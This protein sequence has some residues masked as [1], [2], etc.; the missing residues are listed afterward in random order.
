MKKFAIKNFALAITLLLLTSCSGGGTSAPS[1]DAF[2]SGNGSILQISPE[3]RGVAPTLSGK[4]L[5][6][7][8]T[9]SAGKVTIVNVWA[10]WCSPCRAEAPTLQALSTT[11]PN[12]QFVG[13]LTRD[14]QVTARAFVKRFKIAYPTLVDDAL[15]V[16]FP[17]VTPNA[18]PTTLVLDKQNRVAARISGE[19][20]YTDLKRIINQVS[21]EQ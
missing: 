20:L 17:G 12:V 1:E 14:N 10:S 21:A 18:I 13:I 3:K 6:G 9:Q 2:I 7:T 8:F 11:F 15:L 4:T 19:A 16:A 5:D